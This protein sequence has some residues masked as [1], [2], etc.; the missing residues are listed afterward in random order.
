MERRRFLA[1]LGAGAVAGL[2]GC[3]AVGTPGG[4]THDVGM[5]ATAFRPPEFTVTVG[6]EVVWKNTSSR[7]HT[8]TA[9]GSDLPDGAAYFASG[10]YGSEAAARSGFWDREGG[11]TLTS[12][13]IYRHTFE[14]AGRYPYFCI[15][16][17]RAGMAGAVIVE[18]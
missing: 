15:P 2:A 6:D 16:H 5:T 3:G 11:G 7:G 13:E 9:Y 14:V 1:A 4:D 10:G 17:E 8:V 12:G 18:E